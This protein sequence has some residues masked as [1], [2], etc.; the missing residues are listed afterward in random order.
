MGLF[1]GHNYQKLGLQH[2]QFVYEGGLRLDAA[3]KWFLLK[4]KQLS[5]PTCIMH[6]L[7]CERD[8][9]KAA[10]TLLEKDLCDNFIQYM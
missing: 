6:A 1:E 4:K 3:L 2:T 7:W 9:G 10:E 8:S 5:M